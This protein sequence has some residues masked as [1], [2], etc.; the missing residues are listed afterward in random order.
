MLPQGF[1]NRERA[2]VTAQTEE[3]GEG[4]VRHLDTVLLVEQK[5]SF[6]HAVEQRLDPCLSVGQVVGASLLEPLQLQA[7]TPLTLPKPGASPPIDC[8]Q[9]RKRDKSEYGP[10]HPLP[11]DKTIADATDRIEI[12][13]SRPKFFA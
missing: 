9:T 8:Q 10:K 11:L 13:G 3:S 5:D 4:A 7:R 1:E 6:N 2:H 12:L